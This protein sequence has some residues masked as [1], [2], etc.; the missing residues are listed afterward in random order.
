MR[1]LLNTLYITN[2]KSYLSL[3]GE[4]IVVRLEDDEKFRLPLVNIE[5]IV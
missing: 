1:K 2:E 5:N 3:D 4:N